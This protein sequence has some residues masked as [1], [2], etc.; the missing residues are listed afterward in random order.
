MPLGIKKI[1]KGILTYAR[2]VLSRNIDHILTILGILF[3]FACI[4][5]IHSIS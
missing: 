3:I 2:R 5:G 1:G 4:Y